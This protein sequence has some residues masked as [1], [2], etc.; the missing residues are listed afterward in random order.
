MY[1]CI[2]MSTS[3]V[4]RMLQLLGL[5]TLLYQRGVCKNLEV[6]VFYTQV[7]VMG[8][9]FVNTKLAIDHNGF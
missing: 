6:T 8:P 3:I 7:E 4:E 1:I 5:S 2:L 9:L